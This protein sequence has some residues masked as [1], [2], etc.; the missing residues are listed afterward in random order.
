MANFRD[1]SGATV[2]GAFA[3]SYGPSAGPIIQVVSSHFQIN[4]SSF[5]DEGGIRTFNVDGQFNLNDVTI[6]VLYPSS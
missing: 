6:S 4:K 1:G 3:L 2:P 5:G